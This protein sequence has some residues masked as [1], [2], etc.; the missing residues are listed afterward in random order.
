MALPIQENEFGSKAAA[1]GEVSAAVMMLEW[2]PAMTVPSRG[3]SMA[4]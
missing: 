2:V 3:A 1:P 4:M